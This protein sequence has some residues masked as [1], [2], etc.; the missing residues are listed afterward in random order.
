MGD[1]EVIR[2]L[3]YLLAA[4]LFIFGIK[5][6]THPRTAVRGNMLGGLGMLIAAAV[7]II[8]PDNF[9]TTGWVLIGIGVAIGTVAGWFLALKIQMTAMPQ[10]VALFNGFGGIASFLVA[11]AVLHQYL[12]ADKFIDK[13]MIIATAV[14]GLIGAVTF[15][16]SLIAFAKLQELMPSQP[17]TNPKLKLANG[18]CVLRDHRAQQMAAQRVVAGQAIRELEAARARAVEDPQAAAQHA[19]VRQA[20]RLKSE[21]PLTAHTAY[22]LGVERDLEAL[23]R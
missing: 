6:L 1:F 14:S 9:G 17:Y 7:T 2:N 15:S 3:A 21:Q 13:Q 8:S 22:A 19:E 5:G 4:I 18:A 11:G 20:G 23:D 10:L 12:G 16:G